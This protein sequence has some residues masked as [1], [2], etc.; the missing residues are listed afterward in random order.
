MKYLIIFELIVFIFL[1]FYAGL[2]PHDKEALL[3]DKK[4]LIFGK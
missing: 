4:I 2:C 1:V 3:E